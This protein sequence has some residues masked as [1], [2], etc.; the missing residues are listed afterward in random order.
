MRILFFN[1]LLGKKS[2]N[3]GCASLCQDSH[4]PAWIMQKPVCGN[5][6]TRWMRMWLWNMCSEGHWEPN[7][8]EPW[9]KVREQTR[10]PWHVSWKIPSSISSSMLCYTDDAHPQTQ[11]NDGI[12]QINKNCKLSSKKCTANTWTR[13]TN[14]T[15]MSTRLLLLLYLVYTRKICFVRQVGINDKPFGLT[16]V[17]KLMCQSFSRWR[18]AA[19]GK[20]L[21]RKL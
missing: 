21:A 14:C 19:V 7:R 8:M 10:L 11:A 12:R 20:K 13:S 17:L 1:R 16:G 2:I 5:K 18:I 4:S 9:L 6:S 15:C 3:A